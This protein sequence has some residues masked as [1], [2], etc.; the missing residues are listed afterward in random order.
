M[1]N[2]LNWENPA[3]D[4]TTSA[5]NI[6]NLP[7]VGK[8]ILVTRA[9]GQ[10]SKFSSLLK[11]QGAIVIEMPALEITEPSSWQDLDNAIAK[12]DNFDWLILTS[13]NGVNYFFER[14]QTKGIDIRTL[15]NTKIAVVGRKTAQALQKYNLFPDL[16]PTNFVADSLVSEFPESLTHSKILFPRVETGGREVLVKE[17][18]SQGADVIEVAAYQSKCP[19]SIDPQVW[20][21]LQQ[22]LIDIVTFAS[23]KTVE[24][25]WQLVHKKIGN[26]TEIDSLLKDTQIASIGPQTTKTCLQLLNRIDIEAS[27]YTLEGLTQAMIKSL[28]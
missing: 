10:S 27:E 12:I 8:H 6:A 13:A 21:A 28:D 7:L 18:T 19:P 17:L 20:Q 15:A 1:E 14:F 5:D 4:E 23:S 24:N 16:I 9:A 3:N 22:N 26:Q 2:R 11:Q 25:F